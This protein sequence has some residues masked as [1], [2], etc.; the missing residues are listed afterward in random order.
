[1]LEVRN[2]SVRFGGLEVLHDVSVTLA[3]GRVTGLIGPNG[4]G[5]TTLFDCVTGFVR[6][7][8]G[9]VRVDDRPVPRLVPHRVAA[10][11]IA[12]TF[13]TPRVFSGLTTLENLVV[14]GSRPSPVRALVTAFRSRAR[15]AE[16]RGLVDRAAETA[17]FVGLTP[18]LDNLSDAL[19]GGQRKLLEIGRALMRTPRVL[20][21]DEPM[22]GVHPKLARS[23]ADTLHAVADRG[24][25]VG[26]IEHNME[27]VMNHCD[28][29]HV[30]AR[31]RELVHG[32]PDVV[33]R[34]PQVL[35]AY[36]GGT[37]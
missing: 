37:P 26:V 10:A 19:S 5:K 34:D 6:C 32:P 13:Q 35:A 18:V 21:L 15:A 23:L 33:R 29:V 22:A 3:E 17:E 14:A 25:A 24:V 11:G 7:D 9:T 20:L 1:M 2:V 28:Y 27:F 4:A 8:S 36:L 31:G 12:R 30:L 16:L